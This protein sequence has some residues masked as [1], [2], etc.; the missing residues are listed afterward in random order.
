MV[1][2]VAQ[3]SLVASPGLP[4][5]RI[6]PASTANRSWLEMSI[7]KY[8]MDRYEM[9]GLVLNLGNGGNGWSNPFMLPFTMF[10]IVP[11]LPF[12]H[13]LRWAD[14]VNWDDD[15]FP[16]LMGKCQIHGNQ[17]TNQ[18]IFHPNKPNIK[19]LE[20]LPSWLGVNMDKC[21]VQ[22]PHDHMLLDPAL[23]GPPRLESFCPDLRVTGVRNGK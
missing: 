3:S 1:W 12:S 5:R 22:S 18:L 2:F 4:R 15:S 9:D 10:T 14:F 20:Y 19:G 8:S 16:I 6:P 17:T 13:S 7:R 21:Q 23:L 11:M